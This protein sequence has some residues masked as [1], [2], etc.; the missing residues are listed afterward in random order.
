MSN[1]AAWGWGWTGSAP[2]RRIDA[3]RPAK[4]K[5]ARGA[6]HETS[7]REEAIE[8][9]TTK[10]MALTARWP[11]TLLLTAIL[12]V[13]PVALQLN[14]AHRGLILGYTHA[15]AKDDGGGG[16]NSSGSGSGGNGNGNSGSGLGNSGSGSSG[17][18]SDDSDD[19]SGRNGG[20][21]DRSTDRS[22]DSKT[23]RANGQN[24][25]VEIRGGR[26]IIRY[27]DGFREEISRGVLTLKDPNGRTVVKRPTT[28]GDKARLKALGI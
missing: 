16:G 13:A 3:R 26:I 12:T 20:D 19:N 28:A 25:K 17:S 14:G 1:L 2:T 23:T 11:R 18:G 21:G 5:T 4:L 8:L 9:M 10:H 6:R 27:A 24:A 7:L 22:K 15:V